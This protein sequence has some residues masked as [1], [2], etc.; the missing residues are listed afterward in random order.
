MKKLVRSIPL[1]ALGAFLIYLIVVSFQQRESKSALEEEKSM[2]QQ[3][4]VEIN[5]EI[6]G[7]E[8]E[9][10]SVDSK[11]F[12]EKVAREKLKMVG[13]NDIVYVNKGEIDQAK[14]EEEDETDE[15]SEN[16]GQEG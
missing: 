16:Y 13:P 10:D 11:E 2:S 14:D 15:E 8:E 1:I 5:R 6:D 12:I 4:L 7:L 3:D 9:L